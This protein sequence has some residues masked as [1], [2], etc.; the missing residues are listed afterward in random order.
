MKKIALLALV[1]ISSAN[2]CPAHAADAEGVS[3]PRPRL[4]GSVQKRDSSVKRPIDLGPA[5]KKPSS[6]SFQDISAS[7]PAAAVHEDLRRKNELPSAQTAILRPGNGGGSVTH[8]AG[9]QG[10][11][12]AKAA[13]AQGSTSATLRGNGVAA[14]ETKGAGTNT[15][16]K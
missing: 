10:M 8:G 4:E 12:A 9:V 7:M 3:S 2:C 13:G 15:F 16:F 11:N 1:T 14:P 5:V 6:N